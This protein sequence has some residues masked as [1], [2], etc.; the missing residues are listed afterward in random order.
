MNEF[1]VT[2]GFGIFAT[3]IIGAIAGWIAEKVTGSNH[4]LLTNIVVGVIGSGVGVFLLSKLNV[5]PAGGFF[6]TILV[7]AFGASIVLFLW[8][9]IAGRR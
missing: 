8:R 1:V 4:G 7:A 5:M 6:Y 3:L 2:P 9:M